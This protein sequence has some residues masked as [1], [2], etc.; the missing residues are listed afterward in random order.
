MDSGARNPGVTEG[1]ITADDPREPDTHALL[2]RHLAFAREHTP[3]AD[4]HALEL[5]RLVDSAIT[6]FSYR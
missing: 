3:P 6:F 5:D 4:M 1:E 2:K